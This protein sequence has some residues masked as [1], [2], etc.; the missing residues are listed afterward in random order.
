MKRVLAIVILV[1]M[2]FA[3]GC[4]PVDNGDV[5]GNEN[6]ES[7]TNQGENRNVEEKN[8]DG[9]YFFKGKIISNN[10]DRYIEVE[11]IDS[12]VAFGKYI[13]NVDA[14]TVYVDA[15]GNTITRDS[16]KAD[17]VIEIIFSGQTML[18][19]PPQIYGQKI[20]LK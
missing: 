19:Y 10:N 2:L 5:G 16:L 14:G 15:N 17:D 11:I 7:N 4:R 3:M 9:E 12:Q 8:A 18:S 1:M 6:N 13:V 20:I